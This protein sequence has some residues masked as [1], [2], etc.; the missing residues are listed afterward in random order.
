V[1][2]RKLPFCMEHAICTILEEATVKDMVERKVI[3][4]L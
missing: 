1:P 4:E 3:G 2:F